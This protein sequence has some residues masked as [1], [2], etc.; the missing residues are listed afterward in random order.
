MF[1]LRNNE[2]LLLFSADFDIIVPRFSHVN[3]CHYYFEGH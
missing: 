1:F 2:F 3:P